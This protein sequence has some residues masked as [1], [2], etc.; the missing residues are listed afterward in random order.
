MEDHGDP[1]Y[2]DRGGGGVQHHFKST[3]KY[4]YLVQWLK[5]FHKHDFCY[6]LSFNMSSCLCNETLAKD[7]IKGGKEKVACMETRVKKLLHCRPYVAIISF[8]S[9]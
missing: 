1:L 4:V 2:Y 8:S 5:G 9:L 6:C 7:T 3:L